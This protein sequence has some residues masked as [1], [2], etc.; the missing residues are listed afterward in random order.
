MNS[1][2]E[3][4][5]P[6]IKY[7]DS[8]YPSACFGKYTENFDDTTNFQG[9]SHDVNRYSE[10]A[11]KAKGSILEICCGTGRIAIPLAKEGH[12]VTGVDISAG[13]LSKFQQ[14][15]DFQDEDVSSRVTLVEQDATRLSLDK[16]FDLAICGFN[17]LLCITDFEDQI[18]ALESVSNHLSQKGVFVFDIVNPMVMDFKGSSNPKAFFT[19]K[20]VHT[21][22]TYTRFA[23]AGP[24]DQNQKQELYG[25]Y[26]EIDPDGTVKRDHYSLH[27]RP[28]FRFEIELMLKQAGLRIEKIE[29]GHEG[30]P[31]TANSPRMFIQAVKV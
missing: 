19:R 20:N 22:N 26:D 9:L 11:L 18:R 30:E 23:M 4:T 3:N 10:L 25:W 2:L 28:I 21:G 12:S 24:F 16:K 7:Y 15:L 14:N 17:S 6:S 5:D 1:G 31:F 29:G 27:W 8:D 13:L